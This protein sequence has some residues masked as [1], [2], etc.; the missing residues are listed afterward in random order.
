MPATRGC[1][2]KMLTWP[3]VALNSM[4]AR[5]ALAVKPPVTTMAYN[6]LG[7]ALRRCLQQIRGVQFATGSTPSSSA[8]STCRLLRAGQH[9]QTCRCLQ[10]VG[11]NHLVPLTG[12][13]W[14]LPGLAGASGLG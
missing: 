8:T 6:A 4:E 2:R 13:A 5:S 14:G 1:A 10:T 7:R 9:L 11:P 3:V 12:F